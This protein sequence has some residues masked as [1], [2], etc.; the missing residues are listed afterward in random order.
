MKKQTSIVR[1]FSGIQAVVVLLLV[2]LVVQSCLLWRNCDRGSQATSALER[3]GLPSLRLLAS[4]DEGLAV[5]RLHSYE[6][7]FV[8]DKDRAAKIA[9]TDTTLKTNADTLGKLST[10]YPTG[11]G[12]NLVTT[13]QSS[14]DDYVKT[15]NQI[16][17]LL[18]KD[19]AAAM[20]L[21]DAE[22]PA[23][24]TRLNEA[25]Q[26]LTA[27]CDQVAGQRASLTV[28]SFNHVRTSVIGLGS[29][30][31][32]FALIA[33]VLIGLNVARVRRA[34]ETLANSLGEVTRSLINS[35]AT[36]SSSSQTL[37]T[38]SSE[39]AAS[40]E[41]TSSSLEEMASMTRRNADNARNANELSRSAR[42][43]AEK[44]ASDMNA[45]SAAMHDIKNSSDDIAKIIRTI[46]EIAFQT[47]ILA[48]NAAVEA[49]RAGEAGMGFAVV[50]DEVR[51]LAQRSAQAAKET[52]AKIEGAIA[53]TARGVDISNKVSQALNEI[54]E[55]AR[56]VDELAAEVA[57]ASQEQTHGI[58]QINAAVGQMDKVTQ[59]NA[60]SAEESAAAAQE[61]NQQAKAMQ[62]TVAELLQMVGSND[63]STVT[64]THRAAPSKI[65]SSSPKPVASSA[66]VFKANGVHPPVARDTIPL[67]TAFKDF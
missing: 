62:D 50:A 31:V 9:E 6:L 35:T 16:R 60:A 37:A 58:T 18:D 5:Y 25:D 11:E 40:I 55:K 47:N 17:S 30:S 57:S 39:Q 44:G 41:E 52:A 48:L 8:Q 45:M 43:S 20:K 7:M 53:N 33:A 4:L 56:K 34:L 36:I 22:V 28:D 3:E 54:V 59:A 24:V 65:S 51:N 19:F 14:F 2:F 63:Y 1:T 61:L 42:T 10:L 38:G 23:K 64:A 27:Y 29:A 15:M 32:G 46:D 21:L 67:E 13:L 66:P 49:A 12:H 26:A